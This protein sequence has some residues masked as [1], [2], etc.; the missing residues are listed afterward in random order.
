MF[1]KSGIFKE[2]IDCLFSATLR[3]SFY[4]SIR[5]YDLSNLLAPHIY[6]NYMYM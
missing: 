4:V 6:Y 1:Y 3:Y 5:F 2:H